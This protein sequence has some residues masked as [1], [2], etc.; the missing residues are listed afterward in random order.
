MGG[1]ELL[2][3]IWHPVTNFKEN[4]FLMNDIN[5]LE[6]CLNG[7]D[8]PKERQ[9]DPIKQNDLRK[10]QNKQDYECLHSRLFQRRLSSLL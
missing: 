5:Q 4:K 6:S 3:A 9:Q 1:M 10:G 8:A 7:A 2:P